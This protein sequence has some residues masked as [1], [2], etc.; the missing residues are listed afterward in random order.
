MF[1]HFQRKR[2]CICSYWRYRT[3]KGKRN[4]LW[5]WKISTK[6]YKIAWMNAHNTVHNMRT[7]WGVEICVGCVFQ[8]IQCLYLLQ[9]MLLVNK[10]KY[11]KIKLVYSVLVVFI[12][13]LCIL[14]LPTIPFYTILSTH[15]F[16]LFYTNIILFFIWI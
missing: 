2:I 9:S 11:T 13:L 7:L 5:K 15:T 4:V 3:K 6:K 10:N 8:Y 16:H 12:L 14:E 1:N